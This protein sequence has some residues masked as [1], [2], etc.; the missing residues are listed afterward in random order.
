MN[1]PDAEFCAQYARAREG[2]RPDFFRFK[3]KQ[4]DV[5][6]FASP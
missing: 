1:A 2:V 3:Q 4:W 5:V 6:N